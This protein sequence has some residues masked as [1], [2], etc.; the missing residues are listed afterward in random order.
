MKSKRK[1]SLF[2]KRGKRYQRLS[3]F[4]LYK[5]SA[6]SLF[7]SALLNGSMLGHAMYLRPVAGDDMENADQYRQNMEALR[8]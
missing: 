2:V 8:A 3:P 5:A 4:A 1:Y 7:Q 6:I